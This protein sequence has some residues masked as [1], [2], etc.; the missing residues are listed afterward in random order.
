MD[1]PFYY[2]DTCA[3]SPQQSHKVMD[4]YATT[5]PCPGEGTPSTHMGY[6]RE[7]KQERTVSP[8]NNTIELAS[9]ELEN[10]FI[11]SPGAVTSFPTPEVAV[12]AHSHRTVTHTQEEFS[13]GFE[14]ALQQ[15][16][17]ARGSPFVA[18]DEALTATACGTANE[19]EPGYMSDSASYVTDRYEQL[20]PSA[21][22]TPTRPKQAP[23]DSLKDQLRQRVHMRMSA[24]DSREQ[25]LLKLEHRRARN[26]EAA[27]RCRTKKLRRI[28]DMEER[29]NELRKKNGELT[30][31]ISSHKTEIIRLKKVIMEHSKHG[32]NIMSSV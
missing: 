30:S 29:V 10:M 16:Y 28:A 13:N 2:D 12:A 26:R 5:V 31:T 14:N 7:I 24:I 6:F 8:Y 32:C 25:E 17:R 19:G 22:N 11:S 21:P 27:I 9:P 3:I 4:S 1:S 23:N 20:V 15:V 18:S